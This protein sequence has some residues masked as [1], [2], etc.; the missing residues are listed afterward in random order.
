[1]RATAAVKTLTKNEYTNT[2]YKPP[3]EIVLFF[4]NTTP[5]EIHAEGSYNIGI[6]EMKR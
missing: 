1:L 6:N 5:N 2:K 4:F 3:V